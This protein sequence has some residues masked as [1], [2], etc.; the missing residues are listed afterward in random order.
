[1]DEN[2]DEQRIQCE[3]IE[4]NPHFYRSLIQDHE[5]PRSDLWYSFEEPPYIDRSVKIHIVICNRDS[6]IPHIPRNQL[7]VLVFKN[8]PLI[9]PSVP[10]LVLLLLM[11]WDWADCRKLPDW[12]APQE[13]A[14]TIA[15]DIIDLTADLAEDPKRLPNIEDAQ[16]LPLWFR[17]QGI[18]HTLDTAGN[19]GS[20][21]CEPSS[22]LFTLGF[23]QVYHE[24]AVCPTSRDFLLHEAKA[25]TTCGELGGN[26]A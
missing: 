23:R 12:Q 16:W 14:I 25:W 18:R 1:M 20:Y 22:T 17:N 9:V 5:D 15:K 13:D 8:S 11:L 26:R 3:L 7:V 6:K 24:L 19:A 21:R 4:R 10:P 2:L